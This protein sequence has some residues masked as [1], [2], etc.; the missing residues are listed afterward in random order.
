[1]SVLNES[2]TTVLRELRA[3]YPDTPFLALGQTVWWDEPM[4]AALR[5]LLDD[6]GLGGHIVLGV[7]DTDYFA[8]AHMQLPP[9]ERYAL[10]PHND[11]ST[12]DLWSAAGEISQFMGS[13]CFPTR[14]S[15]TQ[16]GV[17]F[18]W[19]AGRQGDNRP[20]FI[21]EVTAAWGWR[22]LAFAGSAD[23]VVRELRLEDVT[24]G[25]RRMLEWGFDGTIDAIEPP[26]TARQARAVADRL[27]GACCACCRSNPALT[28]TDLYKAM[29][30]RLL[31]ELMQ[32]P[33]TGYTVTS[34]SE[35]LEFTPKTA[36]LPR[37]EFLDLFL[38][39]ATRSAAIHAYNHAVGG[40]EVYSLDKFG[41]GALPFDVVV[42]GL[43]RGTLRVT[44][45][46][47]H[48]ETPQPIRLRLSRPIESVSDLADALSA[49]LGDKVVV[50]GKAVALISMLA[51]EYIFVFNETGS[52]YVHRT[53]S[54]NA[55]LSARGS[56]VTVHPIL[57]LH[58]QTWDSAGDVATSMRLPEPLRGP[59]GAQALPMSQISSRWREVV[60][61]QE[62][63]LAVL[64]S[65][66][67]TRRVLA[68]LAEHEPGRWERLSDELERLM[69]EMRELRARVE[70]IARQVRRRYEEVAS[71]RSQIAEV[72][73]EMS[74]H[75]RSVSDWT[76]SELETRSE[77]A[78]R[79]AD[80]HRRRRAIL[81][82]V[83]ALK[84]H[85]LTMERSS[86][87][88][89]LRE[90]V[91]AIRVRAE[92]A[93]LRLVRDALLTVEGLPH[94]DHRPCAWWL[95]MVDPSGSWFRRIT[96]TTRAYTEPL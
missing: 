2:A 85:R 75:F 11:G 14:H 28:L 87:I 79:L 63:L 78:A 84:A 39:P 23:T 60:E 18:H 4:K 41:V 32:R 33:M 19:L 16:H 3:R 22:G 47:I 25:I 38:R 92:E 73:R 40:S 29:F 55:E 54:M 76:P 48:I 13:E 83:R 91:E 24:A 65:L 89:Q 51:R 27:V 68:F 67:G 56:P 20:A 1:M 46:A 95:P 8:K 5:V 61:K 71:L 36:H 44:L 70:P 77:F 30:P 59:F 90:R 74:R 34:T 12:R 86:D 62:S 69:L 15:L 9:G 10:L 88:Q 43:G 82:E 21:D 66:R 53:R 26:D 96:E 49:H 58:Y 50:V 35:L 17:P 72:E 6:A 80:L 7:H 93:R 45:R 31:E 94:T 42:P 52:M 57:R 37:F 64:S 81:T